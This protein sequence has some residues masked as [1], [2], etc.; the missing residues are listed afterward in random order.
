LISARA[1][2]MPLTGSR[3]G[4]ASFRCRVNRGWAAAS[5]PRGREAGRSVL[6]GEKP[7]D[8]PVQAPTKYKLV[9]NM[10]TARAL[11]L[12]LP[13]QLLARAG[14]SNATA[15]QQLAKADVRALTRGSG[16]DPGRVKTRWRGE[17]IE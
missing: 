6:K 17:R 8:L 5:N 10:K 14:Q 4:A 7:A 15:C 9:I 1:L 13:A 11:G 16:F 2:N 3:A 12:D